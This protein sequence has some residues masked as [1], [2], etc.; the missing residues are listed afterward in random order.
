[1]HELFMA[2]QSRVSNNLCKIL[3]ASN[4]DCRL[5]LADKFNIIK[6]ARNFSTIS[7]YVTDLLCT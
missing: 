1:M 3:T 6:I 2:R 4:Y 5:I 7:H